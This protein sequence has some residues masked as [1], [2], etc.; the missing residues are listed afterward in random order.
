MLQ[1]KVVLVE[2]AGVTG[3]LEA[4]VAAG[5]VADAGQVAERVLEHGRGAGVGE[6]LHRGVA[7]GSVAVAVHGVAVQA[8][9]GSEHVAQAAVRHMARGRVGRRGFP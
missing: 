8:G 9:A 7:G 2:E 1:A 3:V 6:A 4:L 5:R